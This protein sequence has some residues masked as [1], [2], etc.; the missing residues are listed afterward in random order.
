MRIT[1]AESSR[2]LARVSAGL[3]LVPLGLFTCLLFF[4]TG[5]PVPRE[6]L[7]VDQLGFET[8]RTIALVD[9]K[10]LRIWML[11]NVGLY[12][13][14][15]T[16]I[17]PDKE[18]VSDEDE[19]SVRVLE[20][21][22]LREV[23]TFR[24][25]L[26]DCGVL[27][28]GPDSSHAVSAS[29]QGRLQLWNLGS[30]RA[31]ALEIEAPWSDL[32]KAILEW[33]PEFDFAPDGRHLL[34]QSYQGVIYYDWLE[35]RTLTV[36]QPRRHCKI[37]TCFF[38]TRGHPKVI[39]E[40]NGLEIW[41]LSSNE[42]EIKLDESALEERGF[43]AGEASSGSGRNVATSATRAATMFSERDLLLIHSL[44]DGRVFQTHSIPS[45]G[46]HRP[47]FSPDGRF[48]IFDYVQWNQPLGQLLGW[49]SELDAWLWDQFPSRYRMG[50]LDLHTGNIVLDLMGAGKSGINN[51]GTR[52]ISFTDEGRYEYDIPPRWQYFTPWAWAALGAWLSLITIWWKL[53][54]GRHRTDQVGDARVA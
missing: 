16:L 52:L 23:S 53:R 30:G 8:N 41:D 2:R 31:D 3:L 33:Q 42:F 21:F 51:D 29:R 47:Q 28:S 13:P 17:C 5:G 7:S 32:G 38:D 35:R 15:I 4:A 48:L 44:E 49:R 26:A 19:V 54:K 14:T 10:G 46:Y 9:E 40:S 34:I 27:E 50:L 43:M 37:K 24:C 25:K 45:R 20:A 39:V 18:F 11:A 12:S 6:F 1:W 22:T 36:F